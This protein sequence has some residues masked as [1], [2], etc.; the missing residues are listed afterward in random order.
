MGSNCAAAAPATSPAPPFKNP[1]RELALVSTSNASVGLF[2]FSAPSSSPFSYPDPA[3][4]DST[5]NLVS[6]TNQKRVYHLKMEM[7]M[8]ICRNRD[9]HKKT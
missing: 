3:T 4:L 7:S 6:S 8:S 2:S 5:F 9:P 1:R